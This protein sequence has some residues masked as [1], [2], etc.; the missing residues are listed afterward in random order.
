M[1]SCCSKCLKRRLILYLTTDQ[2]AARWGLKPSTI[3]SQRLR[4]Q[5]PPYYTVPRFG[6]PLGEPRVRYQ[7]A[8]VLAF[9]ETHSITPIN[10]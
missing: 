2:L 3:K 1:T 9:E 5:G 7:L 4:G 6:L 8:D 10:P